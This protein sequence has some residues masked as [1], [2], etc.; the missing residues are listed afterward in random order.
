MAAPMGPS[1]KMRVPGAFPP[2]PIPFPWKRAVPGFVLTAFVFGW[3]AVELVR[4]GV[5]AMKEISF[6]APRL[7]V[8]VT[9]PLDQA[10]WLALALG[11]SLASWL[12]AR[13]V[14]GRSG[15]L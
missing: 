15:L 13:R 4:V 9:L 8:A 14:A 1:V 7:P 6:T 10:G 5:P 11:L 2:A 3:G 12:P